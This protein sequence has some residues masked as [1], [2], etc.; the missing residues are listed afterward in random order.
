[1]RRFLLPAVAALAVFATISALSLTPLGSTLQSLR[2]I[3]LEENEIAIVAQG[4]L[5]LSLTAASLEG[6]MQLRMKFT[7]PDSAPP[8]QSLTLYMPRDFNLSEVSGLDVHAIGTV[9][10]E[11][12]TSYVIPLC[13]SSLAA[14][15]LSPACLTPELRFSL[16]STPPSLHL[17]HIGSYP[18]LLQTVLLDLST[19]AVTRETR[20]VSGEITIP[21][22]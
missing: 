13:S 7:A 20:V 6:G 17:T 18:L 11:D 16:P 21:L 19:S 1:V 12:R 10:H 14:H 8:P 9:T 5:K 15:R 2:S 4:K 22:N 3:A